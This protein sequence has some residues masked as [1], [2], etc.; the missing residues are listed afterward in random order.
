MM[1]ALSV[2]CF[3]ILLSFTIVLAAQQKHHPAEGPAPIHNGLWW[4]SKAPPFHDGF[5][6]GYKSGSAH[7]AGHQLDIN[8]FPAIELIDGLDSFYKDFRNRSI[9]V[10]DAL[11]YVQDQLRGVPDDKLNAELLKMRAATAPPST[12]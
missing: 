11:T 7:G 6:T 8:Q 10:D 9:L 5:M 1:R 4:Q 2:F 12:E 3:S